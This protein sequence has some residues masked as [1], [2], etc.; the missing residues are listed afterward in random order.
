MA[1]NRTLA[2]PVL[3]HLVQVQRCDLCHDPSCINPSADPV[4][5]KHAGKWGI[6][7]YGSRE[8]EK[9]RL[10]ALR[11]SPVSGLTHQSEHIA[12]YAVFTLGG[13]LPRG[14]SDEAKQAEQQADAY[15][16][17][18]PAHRA[19]VGTGSSKKTGPSGCAASFQSGRP[20]GGSPR[21]EPR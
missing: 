4:S 17:G 2:S 11:G 13:K 5:C 6:G 14:K 21:V 16:E 9:Q 19:H 8:Y 12:G 15:Y 10:E 20:D 1:S 7:T 3:R 18:P